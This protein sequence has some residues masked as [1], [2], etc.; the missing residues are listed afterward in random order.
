[1]KKENG[2]EKAVVKSEAP[3]DLWRTI[4]IDPVTFLPEPRNMAEMYFICQMVISAGMVSPKQYPPDAAG[5]NKL[6]CAWMM[7]RAVGFNL[8]T[9][10]SNIAV[11]NSRA[12]IFGA[13]AIGVCR[14]KGVMEWLREG[15]EGDGTTRLAWCEVKRKG[16]PAG[17]TYKKTW[18]WE[19]AKAAGLLDDPKKETWKKYIDDM[20]LAKARARALRAAFADVLEGLP[21]AEDVADY[22]QDVIDSAKGNQPAAQRSAFDDLVPDPPTAPP[23]EP[24]KEPPEEPAKKQAKEPADE[25]PP[26]A[27]FDQKIARLTLSREQKELLP[28]FLAEVAR[29]YGLTD[30][31]VREVALEQ[32]KVF[33]SKLAGHCREKGLEADADVILGLAGPPEKERVEETAK[34]PPLGEPPAEDEPEVFHVNFWSNRDDWI[35]KRGFGFKRVVEEHLEDLSEL[36]PAAIYEIYQKWVGS[37]DADKMGVFPLIT[38]ATKY[39]LEKKI[40]IEAKT[41]IED[42]GKNLKEPDHS[43]IP[44]TLAEIRMRLSDEHEWAP[45]LL[46]DL[47]DDLDINVHALTVKTG[48]TLLAAIRDHYVEKEKG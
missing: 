15:F 17:V 14:S 7:G 6:V 48:Q 31:E 18:S 4:K 45:E 10:A 20:L 42:N 16:E 27:E 22:E 43:I 40:D 11:I 30:T 35:N 41:D 5:T 2:E 47:C 24:A 12:S 34:E 44:E 26:M 8:F 25:Q 19:Q 29:N 39:A 28:E 32:W 46:Y 3:V 37:K 23:E 21:I 1:M 9:A 38:Q 36:E 33:V 13:G